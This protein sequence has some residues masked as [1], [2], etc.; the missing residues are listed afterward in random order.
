MEDGFKFGS[1]EGDTES[2]F[3]GLKEVLALGIVDGDIGRLCGEGAS[4]N[5]LPFIF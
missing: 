4:E 1:L 3:D 5:F 2:I